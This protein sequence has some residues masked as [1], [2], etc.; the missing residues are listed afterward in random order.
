MNLDMQKTLE[1]NQVKDE[2]EEFYTLALDEEMFLPS[3]HIYYNDD[4]TEA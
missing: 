3:I 1:E 2:S 4:L